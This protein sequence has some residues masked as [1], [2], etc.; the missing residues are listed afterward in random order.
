MVVFAR[1]TMR[2]ANEASDNKTIWIKATYLK[3]NPTV[4]KLRLNE[5]G[6]NA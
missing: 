2:L 5:G 6:A 1:I 4:S 3:A